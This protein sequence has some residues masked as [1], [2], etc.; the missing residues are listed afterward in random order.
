MLLQP[1]MAGDLDRQAGRL[2][3]RGRRR[4]HG[5][6]VADRRLD[7]G[8]ARRAHDDLRDLRRRVA[9]EGL[10]DVLGDRAVADQGEVEHRRAY[11]RTG[12]PAKERA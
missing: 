1:G 8:D 3:E 4:D 2:A 6:A 9:V 11:L 10:Q 5:D 12:G 7:L